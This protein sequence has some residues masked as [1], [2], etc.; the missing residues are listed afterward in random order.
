MEMSR[1]HIGKDEE[2]P[3]LVLI[4]VK[5]E[6]R[7]KIEL[8]R[9]GSFGIKFKAFHEPLFDNQ[10]TSFATEPVDEESRALFKKYNLITD[11]SFR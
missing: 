2:H 7:L 10:L 9:I 8:N 1:H 4:G 3:S 11:E 5:S 6:E